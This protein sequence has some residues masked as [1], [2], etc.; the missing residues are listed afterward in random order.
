MTQP[1][2]SGLVTD[3]DYG[4]RANNLLTMKDGVLYY[5]TNRGV[6]AAVDAERGK[7]LWLT[8]YPRRLLTPT[9]LEKSHLTVQRDLSPCIVTRG[10]VLAM[11]LDCERLF[12]LD[13]ATGQLIWQ[14]VPGG[15]EPVHLLGTSSEDVL[16]SGEQLFWIHLHSGKV[17]AEFPAAEQANGQTAFGRGVLAGDQVF[18]PTKDKVYRLKLELKEGRIVQPAAPPIDLAEFG[19]QGGNVLVAQGHLIVA[20]PRRLTVYAPRD[21]SPRDPANRADPMQ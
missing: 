15:V 6:I 16:V 5:N 8:R 11:P 13:A 2:G 20:S 17:R 14:T 19:E 9:S 3:G 12:A 4:H 21:I 18:W 10:M 1:Y 7:M